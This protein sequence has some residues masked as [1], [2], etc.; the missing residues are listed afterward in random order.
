[1]TL[2]S[3][4]ADRDKLKIASQAM[5]LT[6]DSQPPLSRSRTSFTHHFT[7][8]RPFHKSSSNVTLIKRS[9]TKH[10]HLHHKNNIHW[11]PFPLRLPLHC[12]TKSTVPHSHSTT[13]SLR[14][15]I[16][17]LRR[18]TSEESRSLPVPR[19][20]GLRLH[21]RLGIG[22]KMKRTI[23]CACVE[24][25]NTL[26]PFFSLPYPPSSYQKTPK[27]SQYQTYPPTLSH[28]VE[29]MISLHSSKPTWPRIGGQMYGRGSR[30]R[31]RGL[32]RCRGL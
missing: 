7:H 13:T 27:H 25:R 26:I 10:T 12:T 11:H 8:Q 19:L 29:L 6:S 15:V 1:M 32:G 4:F 3:K 9:T 17:C 18:K 20:R 31:M 22:V 16:R 28:S 14:R 21:T 24:G 23:P 2:H 5:A 30:E